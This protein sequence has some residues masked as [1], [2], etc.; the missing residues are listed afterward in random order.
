MVRRQGETIGPS[1]TMCGIT[2]GCSGRLRYPFYSERYNSYS[3]FEV[4]KSDNEV[5][6]RI[7]TACSGLAAQR[8]LLQDLKGTEHFHHWRQEEVAKIV[9][10]GEP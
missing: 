3:S 5:I 7:I 6:A 4:T 1:G 8:R 9:H 10:C 2:T